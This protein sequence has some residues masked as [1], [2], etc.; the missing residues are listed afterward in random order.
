MRR[1][2]DFT[3]NEDDYIIVSLV[4][5]RKQGFLENLRR[6]NVML[7]RCKRGMYIVSSRKF[8]QGVGAS[9]LA[10]R[11]LVHY[12]ERAWTTVENLRKDVHKDR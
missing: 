5:S 4:R 8:L 11:L 6:T 10:G 2:Q 1:T 9:C 7:T 12:E 3:G